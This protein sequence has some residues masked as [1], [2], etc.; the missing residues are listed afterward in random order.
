MRCCDVPGR[1]CFTTLI[2]LIIRRTGGVAVCVYIHI[3]THCGILPAYRELSGRAAQYNE[4][5][6]HDE[7]S[8]A[9]WKATH[10]CVQ[11]GEIDLTGLPAP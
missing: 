4:P 11:A 1:R 5:K 8:H 10:Y 6:S 9:P 3:R 2:V 7:H